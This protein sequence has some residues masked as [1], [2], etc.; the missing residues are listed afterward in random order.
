LLT[1]LVKVRPLVFIM[2]GSAVARGCVT[3]MV[4]LIYAKRALPIARLVIEGT[5]GHF[6]AGTHVA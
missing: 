5:K 6:P 1:N 2:D 3:L 4:S